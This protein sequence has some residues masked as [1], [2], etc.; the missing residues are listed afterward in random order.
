MDTLTAHNI[1]KQLN[2]SKGQEQE[3]AAL[4]QGKKAS[5]SK[6]KVLTVSAAKRDFKTRM[7]VRLV[8]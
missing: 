4:L 8:S 5:P 7:K 1:I 2:L 6:S 3:L